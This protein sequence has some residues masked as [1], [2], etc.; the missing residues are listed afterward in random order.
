MPSGVSNRLTISSTS[1]M[2]FP[3][4]ASGAPAATRI[5]GVEITAM[6][7]L[8]PPAGGVAVMVLA[9]GCTIGGRSGIGEPTF[10][11]PANAPSACLQPPGRAI[12]SI[13]G[14]PT[15]RTAGAEDVAAT[16]QPRGLALLHRG[17]RA[18]GPPAP[19]LPGPVDAVG[20][21]A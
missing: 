3:G 18:I 21:G 15:T 19:I 8:A 14:P 1:R 7:V 4:T 2:A 6:M 16:P 11:S 13:S 10:T 17:D 5:D 9:P 20:P 12:Y